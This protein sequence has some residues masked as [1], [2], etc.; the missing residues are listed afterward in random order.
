MVTCSF[1][2]TVIVFTRWP[3][4]VSFLLPPA[5]IVTIF[6]RVFV[7]ALPSPCPSI[8]ITFGSAC[9]PPTTPIALRI[10]DSPL[11]SGSSACAWFEAWKQLVLLEAHAAIDQ[12]RTCTEL[13]IPTVARSNI[14][15]I[16]FIVIDSA[17]GDKM[18]VPLFKYG[19][20]K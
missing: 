17:Q 5:V 3:T 1:S 2:V 9:P 12:L 20:K 11:L 10:S 6:V 16:F 13:K 14:F 15:S 19:A 7:F 4:P 18:I 8:P